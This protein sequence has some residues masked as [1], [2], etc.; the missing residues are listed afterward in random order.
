MTKPVE[1][2][3]CCVRVFSSD[4]MDFRGHMC[5]KNATIERDGKWYC[6]TH[7]PV[8]MAEKQRARDAQWKK[9]R[10]ERMTRH[11]VQQAAFD[12]LKALEDYLAWA[13]D[14]VEGAPDLR[15]LRA[16]MVAAVKQAKGELP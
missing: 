15:P 12:M 1:K 9:D 3:Q 10:E 2:T 16:A 14:V 5:A 4:R 11:R 6:G 8:A 7:D 13:S